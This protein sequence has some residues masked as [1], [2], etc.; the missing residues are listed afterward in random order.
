MIAGCRIQFGVQLPP[1]EHILQP[2]Q[3]LPTFCLQLALA[4]PPATITYQVG[5]HAALS[6][7]PHN[8]ININI[9]DKV[10]KYP[11]CLHQILELASCEQKKIFEEEPFALSVFPLSCSSRFFCTM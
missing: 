7:H 3:V 9:Q 11:S 6:D 1:S 5:E 10:V 2:R 8:I 4:Q